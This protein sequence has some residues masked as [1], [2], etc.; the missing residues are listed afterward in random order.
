MGYANLRDEDNAENSDTSSSRY[1]ISSSDELFKKK[2]SYWFLA[3]ILSLILIGSVIFYCA[4]TG[5]KKIFIT[6]HT[7]KFVISFSAN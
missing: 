7:A 3:L 5:G 1:N 6:L 2:E 4:H